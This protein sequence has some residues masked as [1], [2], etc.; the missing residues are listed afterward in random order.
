MNSNKSNETWNT[1]YLGTLVVTHNIRSMNSSGDK[2]WT[3][4]EIFPVALG[5]IGLDWGSNDTIEEFTV[6]LAYDYWE[7]SSTS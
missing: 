7:S 1:N 6:D 3:F 2:K 4:N 5:E